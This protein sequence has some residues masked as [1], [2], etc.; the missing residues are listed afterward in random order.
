MVYISV[1]TEPIDC[2][3]SP[4]CP[5]QLMVVEPM[6]YCVEAWFHLSSFYH[7][8]DFSLLY[9]LFFVLR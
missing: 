7:F 6:R 4:D 3:R 9:A 2:Y 1:Q 8:T 5:V